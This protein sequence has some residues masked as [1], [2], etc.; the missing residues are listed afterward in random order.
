MT[1]KETP[2]LGATHTPSGEQEG[3]DR[4]TVTLSVKIAQCTSFLPPPGK[5]NG[6]AE[7]RE[8]QSG[9]GRENYKLYHLVISG[10]GM[11]GGG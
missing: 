10:D 3:L 1:F 8:E 7:S 5:K 6:R 4:G 9:D 11:G 2:L